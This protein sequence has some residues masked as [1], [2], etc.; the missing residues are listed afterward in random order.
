MNQKTNSPRVA[1][2]GGGITGATACSTLLAR[3]G[4][5]VHIE[6]FDQGRSGVGGRSS[7]RNREDSQTLRWDHGCQVNAKNIDF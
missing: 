2:V 4:G 3:F 7:H 5:D 6:V 1:I